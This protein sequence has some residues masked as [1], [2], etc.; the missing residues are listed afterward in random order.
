MTRQSGLSPH[1]DLLC[2]S[3]HSNVNQ[4]LWS[5][6]TVDLFCF[7]QTEMNTVPQEWK[8]R[9][10]QL[11]LRSNAALYLAYF[12]RCKCLGRRQKG[13]QRRFVNDNSVYSVLEL[14]HEELLRFSVGHKPHPSWK[15]IGI[16][17]TLPPLLWNQTSA[18]LSRP[19][20]IT[21]LLEPNS[22]TQKHDG[23][24]SDS[25]ESASLRMRGFFSASSHP[26]T[27]SCRE[28]RSLWSR[29]N[30]ATNV[31]TVQVLTMISVNHVK[32]REELSIRSINTLGR[33]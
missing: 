3:R 6:K 29:G 13:Q 4:Q 2:Q 1:P 31:C 14:K 15:H 22:A 32:L 19:W 10:N 16:E 23:P 27:L 33:V 24:L 11:N 5:R 18:G 26:V 20:R 17:S 25:R 21:H 8:T 9:E 12:M 7:G 30:E 28:T